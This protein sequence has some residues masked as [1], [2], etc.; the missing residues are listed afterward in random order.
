MMRN[1]IAL[2]SVKIYI[3]DNRNINIAR[4]LKENTQYLLPYRVERE[5]LDTMILNE[6]IEESAGGLSEREPLRKNIFLTESNFTRE[7]QRIEKEPDLTKRISA[8]LALKKYEEVEDSNLRNRFYHVWSKMFSIIDDWDCDS[9]RFFREKGRNYSPLLT[10]EKNRC[11]AFWIYIVLFDEKFRRF[12]DEL[13]NEISNILS[14]FIRE[15][16]R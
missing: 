3:K 7:L 4:L 10:Y 2:I 12:D 6:I 5:D 8:L 11:N 15:E 1:I 9:L 13:I 14:R 16:K